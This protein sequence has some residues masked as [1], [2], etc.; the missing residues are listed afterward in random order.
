MDLSTRQLWVQLLLYPGHTLPTALA[1]V[2]VGVGLAMHDNVFAPMPA[3]LGFLASWFVHLGGVFLDN[4]ELLRRHPDI[5][6]HPE[7]ND[8]V[9]AGTLPLGRLR[10]ATV[11]CF[12]LALLPG[13]YLY[14]VGGLPVVLLGLV[15][16]IASFAYAGGPAYVRKGLTEPVFFTMFGLVAVVGIYYIQA[17]AHGQAEHLPWQVWV[18][19]LPVGAL[20]TGVSVIDDLR[21]RDWDTAKGWRTI[22][23]R[24]GPLVSV[25]ALRTLIAMAYLALP[26]FVVLGACG[27]WVLIAWASLPWALAV[28]RIDADSGASI[29]RPL[30]ARLAFIA[31]AFG[32]LLGLGLAI[33]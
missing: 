27:P 33:G 5:R 32:M 9:A 2:A 23:V 26:A 7:L 14:S 1:P 31:M 11:L 10:A 13:P 16:I 24:H 8:A 18:V 28:A 4:H 17:A 3:L 19:G 20:V 15:G 22:A 29:L 6:E 25:R 12:A 21:D 30:T